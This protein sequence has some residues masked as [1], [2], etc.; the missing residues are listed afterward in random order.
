MMVPWL[1]LQAV[2]PSWSV[3]G[4]VIPSI[5]MVISFAAAWWL[6]KRFSNEKD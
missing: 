3:A 4:I 1:M 5:V 2:R 6:Y